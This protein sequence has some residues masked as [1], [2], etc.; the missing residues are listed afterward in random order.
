[1]AMMLVAEKDFERDVLRSELPVLVDLYAD[2]C[3]PC[4]QLEPIL[5]QLEG[6]LTGKVKIVRVNIDHSPNVAR[7]FR[8]QSIPMMVLLHQGRPIDQIMGLADKKTIL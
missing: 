4:K 2:W 5:N 6:E 8:V 7:A 3:Q 1:M